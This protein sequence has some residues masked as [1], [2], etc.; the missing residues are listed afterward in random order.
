LPPKAARAVGPPSTR[1]PPNP[2][3]ATLRL[4]QVVADYTRVDAVL[5]AGRAGRRRASGPQYPG[6]AKNCC[7]ADC[8]EPARRPHPY[9][10]SAAHR[11]AIARLRGSH[12]TVAVAV[13]GSVAILKAVAA[14][15][16]SCARRFPGPRSG[17]AA[18][19]CSCSVISSHSSGLSGMITRLAYGQLTRTTEFESNT[20][21]V[22]T[23]SY[24]TTTNRSAVL[25]GASWN[26]PETVP[27]AGTVTC[28]P[29]CRSPPSIR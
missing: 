26:D 1:P 11:R 28:V 8:Y 24:S 22:V 12:H 20:K 5:A 16:R 9:H 7:H 13:M 6:V 21:P 2:P 17:Q 29:P 18:D 25:S 15:P 4:L 14:P 27:S 19:A 23:S 3:G 10:E